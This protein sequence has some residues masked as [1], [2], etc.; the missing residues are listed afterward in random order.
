MCAKSSERL[1]PNPDVRRN[2][3]DQQAT[4]RPESTRQHHDHNVRQR[5]AERGSVGR[6]GVHLTSNGLTALL[7]ASALSLLAACSSAPAAKV[8]RTSPAA[9]SAATTA[10]QAPVIKNVAPSN[11]ELSPPAMAVGHAAVHGTTP[12]SPV[13][14][15]VAVVDPPAGATTVAAVWKT[16]TALVGKKVTVRGKVV[17][18]NGGIL[19]VNWIHLQDGTGTAADGSNDVTVTT[20]ME[21]KVGNLITITGIVAVDKDLGSGYKYPVIIEHATIANK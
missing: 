1:G 18:Y 19:G 12:M 9:S 2:R 20:E 21:T 11:G 14:P 7:T 13:E 8:E 16:R 3:A 6:E 4:N 10:I 17:K 15:P 5:V